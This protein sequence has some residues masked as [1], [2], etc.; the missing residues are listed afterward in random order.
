[1]TDQ[2]QPGGKPTGTAT[3]KTAGTTADTAMDAAA[4]RP[5]DAPLVSIIVVSYNTREMTLEALQ[6][7][8][9]ETT[10]P[11]EIITVD[12]A[13]TDGSAEAIA[14]AFP[15]D[16]FP[17]M[18]FLPETDNHGF[19][20]A[21][22]IAAKLA[23]GRYLLLLNPDT[24]VLDGAIDKLVAFAEARPKAKVWGGRTLFGDRSLNPTNCWAHMSVWSL[25]CRVT[26]LTSIF[27]ASPIFNPEAYGDW[28]RDDEREVGIVTGC[29]FL[30]E[31]D[32]WNELDGFDDTFVMYGEEADLCLRATAAGARPRITPEAEIVH[33]VGAASSVG[34]EKRIMV[35]RAKVSL[36]ER[37]FPGWQRPVGLMLLRLW[38]GTR[39]L[40][41]TLMGKA[42]PWREVWQRRGEWL[43]GWSKQQGV[44]G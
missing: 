23:R 28:Q 24:I 6:S 5:T 34:V 44:M 10:I 12:N 29:F 22:N 17:N 1:M 41:A 35:M 26:G 4:E 15:A 27:A 25:V 30:I 9:D 7:A 8:L 43:G 36:I 33:Y 16:R 21:N 11:H 3:E 40:A 31:R 32:F 13:S 18:T 42:S 20:K 19:A 38:A 2:T 14:E 39:A 37:H